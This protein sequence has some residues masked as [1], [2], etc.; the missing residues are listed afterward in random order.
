MHIIETQHLCHVYQGNI[1]ALDTINFIAPRNCRIA[2]IGPNGA[3]KSTLF[4]HLNGILKPTSG[5]VLIHGEPITK[6]NIREVRKNVGIVF[7]NPDDQ[8]FS[9]TVEQDVAFGPTN[10]GLDEETVEHRVSEALQIVGLENYRHRVPHHLSGGEK[11]RVAIAGILAM[12]PM[13]LV[14]DEPTAGLDP[15]GVR[16]LMGY[17]K[18]LSAEYGM[19]VIFSTHDIS[20]V[21]ELAEYIYVMNRG[22]FVAEGTVKEV[23]AQRELL[24]S[25]RLEVPVLPKLIG[26]M[27]DHKVDIRMGYTYDEAEKEFLR[28]F[29]KVS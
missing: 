12:E 15:Q 24:K 18:N 27:Q 13:A 23:F 9:P 26:S 29:G 5:K 4:K 25:V 3:G 16:D 10:L 1:I 6:D 19:A 7:Q 20:L 22:T 11:K 17:I 2:V 14:L 8:I 28:A 21:S